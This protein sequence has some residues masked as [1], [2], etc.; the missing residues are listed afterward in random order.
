MALFI[1]RTD[2]G[3]PLKHNAIIRL[4]VVICSPK[5]NLLKKIALVVAL[6]FSAN[7]SFA[8]SA[9]GHH[10]VAEIAMQYLSP[11][12]KEAVLKILRKTTPEE[13]A[14]WMDDMRSNAYYAYMSHWHYVDIPKDSA[15]VKGQGDNLIAAINTA[16][17]ELKGNKADKAKRKEDVMI[18]FHLIG[19]MSQPLHTGY[20]E[21]KG[22]NDVQVTFEGGGDNLHHVW[23]DDIIQA[24]HITIDTCLKAAAS[25]SP[26]EIKNIMGGNFMSWMLDSRAHLT[27]VYM[28]TGHK[29]D[30]EYSKRNKALVIHQLI[31]G[32]LRLARTLETLFG[33][34]AIPAGNSNSGQ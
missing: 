20:P 21:D 11:T 26:Q 6:I 34:V 5:M 13:A 8:W 4:P 12:A 2:A 18:L 29:L 9:D 32:G 19:D 23:D 27:E 3:R 16:F 22:G 7:L 25:L 24:E 10:M 30:E 31:A 1:C 17:N 28:F 33:P 14:T 15:Y